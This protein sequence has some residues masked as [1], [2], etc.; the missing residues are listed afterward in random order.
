MKK[1]ILAITLAF[2]ISNA[3][4]QYDEP[5]NKGFKKENLFTGGSLSLS[6]FNNTF[7]IGGSPVLGYKIA[8][9][10]DAGIVVNYQ[11]TSIRD[12]SLFDDRLRQSIYGGGVFTRLYPVNFIF[13]QVQVEHNFISQKYIPPSGSSIGSYKAKTSSNS[14]LVGGGYAT[15]RAGSGNSP[16]F[17]LS[18]LV[19]VSGNTNSPYTD[20]RGRTVPVIRAGFNLP[21]FQGNGGSNN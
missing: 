8:N 17:Y 5:E 7:L 20:G 16:F 13:A 3:S 10:I 19:D 9:F 18:L 12:Y 4:A 21:L 2:L 15:G 6:F 11:Y 1:S 14:L